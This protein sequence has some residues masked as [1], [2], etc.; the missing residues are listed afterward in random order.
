M[1]TIADLNNLHW[2]RGAGFWG[3]FPLPEGM[4][5]L[6]IF[7]FKLLCPF[8]SVCPLISSPERKQRLYF[9]LEM[10]RRVVLVVWEC[11]LLAECTVQFIILW[12]FYFPTQPYQAAIKKTYKQIKTN[13]LISPSRC[14]VERKPIRF[15][16]FQTQEYN[17]LAV[18]W[19]FNLI[20]LLL[21]YVCVLGGKK[22]ERSNH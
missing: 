18:L 3:F 7:S 2:C 6:H 8:H 9:Y 16:C 19:L 17:K 13:I 22:K 1:Q 4:Q 11:F 5:H 14:R 21:F 15:E 20:I 12:L 10:F